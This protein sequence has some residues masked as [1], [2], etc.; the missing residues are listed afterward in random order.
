MT[1]AFAN[2]IV[3]A[4]GLFAVAVF[5]SLIDANLERIVRALKWPGK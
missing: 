3:L 2:I 1:H 4:V 5:A